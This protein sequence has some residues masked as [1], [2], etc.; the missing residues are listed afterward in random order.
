M[1]AS[2][3]VG[4]AFAAFWPIATAA[5]LVVRDPAPPPR[6]ANPADQVP[7][8]SGVGNCNTAPADALVRV[9]MRAIE[10]CPEEVFK[11]RSAYLGYARQVVVGLLVPGGS[12]AAGL[13]ILDK[14]KEN[15]LFCISGALIDESGAS[16]SDKA[17]MKALVAEAKEISDRSELRANFRELKTALKERGL[18]GYVDDAKM[19]GFVN[20]LDVTLQERY[21]GRVLEGELAD[22]GRARKE[23]E[24]RA[25]VDQARELAR[26]CRYDEAEARLAQAQQL[27]LAYLADL[28]ARVSKAKHYRYCLERN[29]RQQPINALNPASPFLRQALQSADADIAEAMRRDAEETA[30][31]GGLADE[32]QS[33]QARRNDVDTLKRR[34]ARHLESARQA[35]AECDW[36]GAASALATL[37]QETLDC[38]VQLDAERRAREETAAQ[39]DEFKRQIGLFEAEFAKTI[40][41]PFEQ[42]GSCGELSVFADSVDFQG[43]CRAL[44]GLDAKISALRQRAR[45]CGDYKAAAAVA[46]VPAAGTLKGSV[47]VTPPPVLEESPR[48]YIRKTY[49]SNA[50]TWESEDRYDQKFARVDWN[51]SGVP[52]SLSPGQRV[53]ITI[54]GGV[55]SERP[56]GIGDYLVLAGVVT[57][58]GD[59][60]PQS[61]QQAD[62]GHAVGHHTFVVNPNA[63]Y[64]E[65][66][67]GG[68]PTGTGAVW[69]YS[70]GR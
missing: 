31:I 9:A 49:T 37:D 47:T 51:Y 33:F 25:L 42:I 24:S 41:I 10:S 67:L 11:S 36:A 2:R 63:Q 40:A 30:L 56:K 53:T 44:A 64:V 46:S 35:A 70:K 68:F 8:P 29:A 34:A 12:E 54:T 52:G 6:S 16:A 5:Q 20:T 38:A 62:R 39:I 7:Y 13:L 66:Q 55:T 19:Q 32:Q 23:P 4:L 60:T 21:D 58:S 27:R 22:A 14:A 15:A 61:V 26:D 69:K 45:E 50:A 18:A 57:V 1:S 3:L 65:I 17:Y 28:R 48:G 59:I 43:G